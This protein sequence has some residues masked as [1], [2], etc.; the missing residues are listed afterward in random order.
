MTDDP[1]IPKVPEVPKGLRDLL[2]YPEQATAAERDTRRTVEMDISDIQTSLS[3]EY[4][5]MVRMALDNSVDGVV[6]ISPPT[7]DDPA[8][9][10][11]VNSTFSLITGM[12]EGDVLGKPLRIFRV[13]E[14]DQAVRDA[15]LHPL[16]QRKS[17]EGEATAIRKNGTRYTLHLAMVPI[18]GDDDRV[19]L[20]VAYL[21]DVSEQKARIASLEHQALHDVLT[22]LPNRALLMKKLEEAID[23][24]KEKE[25]TEL[26]GLL[27][28]DLDRF[29][30]VNDTFGHHY[31]DKLLQQVAERLREELRSGQTVARMG[32]DEFSLVLPSISDTGET[33]RTAR[34]IINALQYP[35][36]IENQR[37][38]IGT[39]IGIT[40][41]PE[42]GEDAATLL[43]R[44]DAS[45]YRA[46]REGIGFS[47]FTPELENVDPQALSLGV[48][49]RQA[50]DA[51]MLE[52]YYQ[53]KVH[54]RTGTVV[55]VEALARWHN[56]DGMVLPDLFIP[57]AERTGLIGNFTEWAIDAALGQCREWKDRGYMIPVAINISG[58]SFHEHVL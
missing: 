26:V 35:F 16:C 7:D 43:R 11:F 32:G 53:P 24:A 9:I 1:F 22:N 49:L 13:E 47:V 51:D 54:L 37:F 50:I 21:R 23:A 41:F 28:M 17:F 52:L 30:E 44:A 56:W 8:R 48:E 27:M 20:W 40:V 14:S 3:E 5:S 58:K 10:R 33:L 36:E 46:K 34:R 6:V 25:G 39:S 45:M 31:G 55:G 42:H 57:L 12:S 19:Q 38:E 2:H 15:L 18:R 4:Q 29:K